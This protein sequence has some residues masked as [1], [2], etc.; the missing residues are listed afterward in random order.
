[1]KIWFSNCLISFELWDIDGLES[2]MRIIK[3]EVKKNKIVEIDDNGR[4][5]LGEGLPERK[6]L[7]VIFREKRAE[8]QKLK[9]EG[10]LDDNGFNIDTQGF[11]NIQSIPGPK[12]DKG[13]PGLPGPTKALQTSYV[14]GE[15]VPD[16]NSSTTDWW[17][18]DWKKRKLMTLLKKRQ[19]R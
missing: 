5:Y 19:K 7:N 16:E 9:K 14:E 15:I 18:V 3:K 4:I 12:G 13:E 17:N 10:G 8:I 11:K 6:L 2:I 1:M